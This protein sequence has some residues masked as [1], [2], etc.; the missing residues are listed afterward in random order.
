MR[1]LIFSVFFIFLQITAFSQL[2]LSGKISDLQGEPLAGATVLL[3]GTYLGVITDATGNFEFQH[4]NPGNYQLVVSFI[5]YESYE[6][7]IN[8]QKNETIIISLKTKTYIADEVIVS[9]QRASNE[10]PVA[11]SNLNKSDIDKQNMGQ[12]MP[13]LMK[14]QPSVITTTDAGTGIGYTGLR[15]RGVGIRGI[16][17]TINGIP[18][19]DPESQGVWWVDLPDLSTSTENIQI[20]RG[21]GTSTNGAGAFGASININTTNSSSLPYGEINS[22]AGLYNTFKNNVKFGT[23]LIHKRLSVDGSFSKIS[24]DGYIDRAFSNLKSMSL[25]AAYHG[26]NSLLKFV[27]LSGKEKTYQAWYG[28]PLAS[29]D[30][31]RTYNPYTYDNETD[32]YQQDQYQLL[33]SK[34]INSSLFMNAALFYIYGRGYYESYKNNKK[35]S[36][37]LI[38]P[39]QIMAPDTDTIIATITNSDIITRKW[40]DN[41]FYGSNI[42]LTYNR[43][44]IN[45]VTGLAG[46]YY[47]GNHFGQVIW[48]QYAGNSSIRHEWYRGKGIKKDYNGFT[49][50]N[51]RMLPRLSLYADLQYRFI[52]YVISGTKDDLTQLNDSAHIYNFF[53]PKTGWR[54]QINDKMQ[55]YFLFAV[56]HREPSRNNFVDADAGKEPKHETL[57]DYEL[58]YEA[59]LKFF[60]LS[61]NLYY[62][63]YKDQLINTGE[64]NNVGAAIMTNVPESFRRGVE[65][66]SAAKLTKT[67]QWNL[68]LTISQNKIKNY[69][70]HIDNWDFAYDT[71][72]SVQYV[73]YL[74]TTDIS[75]SPSIILGSSLD[76]SHKGFFISLLSKY[77]GRQFIDNTSNIDR[78][79]DPYFVTDLLISYSFHTKL[80]KEIQIR[81]KVN[82]LLNTE[83]VSNAWVYQ[84]K[85]G[86]GSFDGSYGDIY[87]T[88]QSNKPGY[89]N[90]AGYFPQAP[91]NVLGGI[92][93]KF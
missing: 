56:A 89:Y 3:K 62:M 37:Y 26:N 90:M 61:A 52:H 17:V 35:L 19:N 81:L 47:D 87:S 79:L 10:I 15:I 41:D 4:L 1:F 68:N 93:I 28:M 6:Q 46:N 53:N 30:T 18:L 75:F 20:Q 22:F 11:K 12:D 84:Y 5:G 40:L 36:D 59:N 32:N 39:V 48:T 82:N 58:G 43:E 45:I 86:D 57:Y 23:G 13:V 65:L 67:L 91:I 60:L 31:N 29:L 44:K 73:N 80:F 25:T 69:T 63:N 64:I 85:S 78:S 14:L 83:Y 33:Y 9:A 51:Y 27:V 50:L 76:F 21:V 77:I 66:E 74:G 34:R 49:K 55:T 71:L 16:N 88:P 8:L 72:Q 38:N 2:K 70:D 42:S 92:S 24:S 54:Y 7:Q